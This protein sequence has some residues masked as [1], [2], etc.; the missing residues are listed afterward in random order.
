MKNRKNI[1]IGLSAFILIVAVGIMTGCNTEQ[2]VE[3]EQVFNSISYFGNSDPSDIVE[4]NS[5]NVYIFNTQHE[6]DTFK[7]RY[8][9]GEP[10][11]G[12]EL[13]ENEK[14]MFIHT[15]W[16]DMNSGISY[17]AEAISIKDNLLDITLKENGI[18][19]RV[20]GFP[21]DAWIHSILIYKVNDKNIYSDLDVNLILEE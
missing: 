13:L 19:E 18:L 11:P 17:Y 9:Q 2:E 3:F 6:W 10:I 14:I 16:E 1:I 20:T 7:A 21:E 15:K 8:L 5:N 4:L 12:I